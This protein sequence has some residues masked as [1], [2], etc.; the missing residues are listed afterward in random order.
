VWEFDWD[1]VGP[2]ILIATDI[3][4]IGGNEL[5]GAGHVLPGTKEA[6]LN[7]DWE[8]QRALGHAD[9]ELSWRRTR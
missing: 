3:D 4:S 1:G 6:V 2:I 8:S 5:I 9:V 7:E